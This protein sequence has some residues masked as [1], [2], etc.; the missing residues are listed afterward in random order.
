MFEIVLSLSSNSV[1][2]VID[3]YHDSTSYTNFSSHSSGS[4][5][6]NTIEEYTFGVPR[7]PLEVF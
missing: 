4:S 7:V 1:D 3:E 6:G 2:K 5:S